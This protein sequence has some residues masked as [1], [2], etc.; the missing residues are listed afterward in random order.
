MSYSRSLERQIWVLER[1]AADTIMQKLRSR[2]IPLDLDDL[3]RGM[4]DCMII[5]L[6]QQ[7]RRPQVVPFLPPRIKSLASRKTITADTI[8]VF[9]LSIWDYVMSSQDPQI[10]EMKEHFESVQ[11]LRE[12]LSEKK[13]GAGVMKRL[14][15]GKYYLLFFCTS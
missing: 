11:H 13:M 14:R 10:E 4:G 12:S 6:L 2:S 3:T 1:Y 9:R 7:C 8:N 15:G 5:A